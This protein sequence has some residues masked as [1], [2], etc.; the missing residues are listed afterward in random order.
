MVIGSDKFPRLKNVGI[1]Q[2]AGSILLMAALGTSGCTKVEP[3]DKGNLTK[4]TMS[5][6]PWSMPAYLNVKT[7]EKALESS[8][9]GTSLGG[10]G[11]GCG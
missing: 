10:G 11:C 3:W 4:P 6:Q 7:A 2:A 8:R 5:V 9:G 1:M